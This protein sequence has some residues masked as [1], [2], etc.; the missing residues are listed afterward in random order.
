MALNAGPRRA[1]LN[2]SNAGTENP[3]ALTLK[4]VGVDDLGFWKCYTG[5]SNGSLNAKCWDPDAQRVYDSFNSEDV[6]G[7]PNPVFAAVDIEY[8]VLD[9]F[10]TT[11]ALKAM[12]VAW[13]VNGG[14]APGLKDAGLS[15]RYSIDET[16]PDC[17][18]VFDEVPGIRALEYSF[19]TRL[20]LWNARV[21]EIRVWI[22]CSHCT[23][24]APTS[25][26]YLNISEHLY[27]LGYQPLAPGPYVTFTVPLLAEINSAAVTTMQERFC[28]ANW[29]VVDERCQSRAWSSLSRNSNSQWQV[30][31]TFLTFSNSRAA[32]ASFL[33]ASD[34]AKPDIPGLFPKIDFSKGTP[35]AEVVATWPNP[36]VDRS[37]L[38]GC[39]S[40]YDCEDSQFCSTGALQTAAQG[41]LGGSGPGTTNFG[42]DL[43]RYCLS[44]SHDPNDRYCPRDRCGKKAGSYPDCMDSKKLFS[45]FTCQS[46]FQI[47]MSRVPVTQKISSTPEVIG[48]SNVNSTARK[49]R[50][51]TPYNQL[52]GAVTVSQRRRTT[53]CSLRND[54]IGRYASTK[55]ISLGAI[56]VN[57]KISAAPFG[58]DPAFTSSS[59]LYEGYV[60]QTAY[61]T[62]SE[63][64]PAGG[65]PYGFFPHR[66]DG[67]N[68]STKNPIYIMKGEESSFKVYF[69]ERISSK[70]AQ[71]MV[72]Y[73][74][75]GGFLDAQ[76]SEVSVEIVTLNSNLNVFGVYSFVFT[77]Q[78]A[79]RRFLGCKCV[80]DAFDFGQQNGKVQWDY[81]IASIPAYTYSDE[82]LIGRLVLELLCVMMLFLNCMSEI[83]GQKLNSNG[84]LLS[85]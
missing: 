65:T 25:V 75:D 13:Q 37:M 26:S 7:Y 22:C 11:S 31:F 30:E 23:S 19:K 49:A 10:R 3:L 41:F 85:Y 51:L 44:D 59:Q 32:R 15:L 67:K 36:K 16:L 83:S 34:I 72:N 8:S 71:R 20:R 54:S 62:R 4:D 6:Y 42:C 81:K 74:K 52:I 79:C 56:C 9:V 60:D 64:N 58:V 63:T 55:L 29:G 50:F 69:T 33:L 43:C 80:L 84:H 82:S 39:V 53:G 28:T 38:V 5:P 61:Y 27:A 35:V 78:V 70:Q 2:A 47:N 76:T 66:Y 18:G 73:L 14:A 1:L 46:V 45:N 24:S 40:H 12:V 68:H 57:E 17:S 77:W 21:D 48:L